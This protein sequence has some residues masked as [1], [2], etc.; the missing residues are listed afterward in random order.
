MSIRISQS[1]LYILLCFCFLILLPALK[2]ISLFCPLKRAV[3]LKDSYWLS[4]NKDA[5]ANNLLPV[6]KLNV[7]LK[8]H[9]HKYLV[10]LAFIIVVFS[11]FFSREKVSGKISSAVYEMN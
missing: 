2:V 9:Q 1:I 3:M 5:F 10:I 11:K 8:L 6:T 7:R 4:A